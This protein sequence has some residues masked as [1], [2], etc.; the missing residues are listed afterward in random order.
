MYST[1]GSIHGSKSP[2]LCSPVCTPLC[3]SANGAAF[4]VHR[5]TVALPRDQHFWNHKTSPSLAGPH[6]L[7]PSLHR[8]FPSGLR[9][10][11]QPVVSHPLP[12]NFL[13]LA[14]SFGLG[15]V[16]T[17][18]CASRRSVAGGVGDTRPADCSRNLWS[19]VSRKSPEATV[20]ACEDGVGSASGFGV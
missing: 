11:P 14:V 5:N 9:N 19:A 20:S 10:F 6:W 17:P 8:S 1:Q 13:Q 18:V 3:S 12:K 15:W 4:C 7:P 16:S 2:H